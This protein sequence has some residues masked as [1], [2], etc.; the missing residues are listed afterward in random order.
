M[1]EQLPAAIDRT[2][3]IGDARALVP[4][5]I[6]AAGDHA[7]R[8]FLKFFAANIRNP[9][10]RRAYSRAV[11]EFMTWC[12]ARGTD[13][14]AAPGGDAPSVQLAGDRPGDPDKPSRIGARAISYCKGGQDAGAGT[15]GSARADRQ[16]RD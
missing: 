14:Q 13:R 16:H 11:S 8:R 12:D 9:H 15:G 3:I 7:A 5:L 4:A 6:A 10:T 2:K 1:S